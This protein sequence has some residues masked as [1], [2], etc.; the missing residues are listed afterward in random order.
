MQPPPAAAQPELLFDRDAIEL[1][2][3]ARV[4]GYEHAFGAQRGASRGAVKGRGYLEPRK[5]P[6]TPRCTV[7]LTELLGT[8]GG[9]D[10]LG[11]VVLFSLGGKDAAELPQVS[12]AV[13]AGL[14]AAGV[15]LLT[16]FPIASFFAAAHDVLAVLFWAA[17]ASSSDVSATT[18]LAAAMGAAA[19]TVVREAELEATLKPLAHTFSS[20]D[21]VKAQVQGE[22][23]SRA[24]DGSEE[25]EEEE[26]EDGIEVSMPGV[27]PPVS[28]AA[29]AT[30]AQATRAMSRR[31]AATCQA[32]ANATGGGEPAVAVAAAV[33]AVEEGLTEADLFILG[34]ILGDGHVRETGQ[35][36][37][38]INA[39]DLSFLQVRHLSTIC[40]AAIC[41]P[42][43]CAPSLTIACACACACA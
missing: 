21:Q 7:P 22:V 5:K 42:R 37:I 34:F 20:V 39:R 26:E 38:D 36:G 3:S 27:V 30:R 19:L 9:V 40:P 6:G 16:R 25:E 43:Q 14:S 13:T 4:G 12:Q 35:P 2:S 28:A 18:E 11:R 41:P 17:V 8:L 1:S 33:A 32:A 23:Y 29:Q 10:D 31:W 24:P 15:T